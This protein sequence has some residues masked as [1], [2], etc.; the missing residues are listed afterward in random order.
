MTFPRRVLP[1]ALSLLLGLAACG[2]E[3]YDPSPAR[4][5][6]IAAPGEDLAFRDP[7]DANTRALRLSVSP[8]YD[9]AAG[10]VRMF[11]RVEDQ[12]GNLI[13]GLNE[14]NFGITVSPKGAN[15]PVDPDQTTVGTEISAEKITSLTIDSSGSM[16]AIILGTENAT[17]MQV[18]KDAAK[19]F[20]DL[21]ESGDRAAVVDF[22]SDARVAQQLTGDKDALERAID[23]LQAEGAT[24]IGDALSKAIE[25]VGNRPGKRAVILLTDGD[26][27]VDT[28][29]GGPSAWLG[30]PDSTR[31]NALEEAKRANLVVY[32]IGLGEDLSEDGLATLQTIAVE[33][34]GEFFTAIT[35]EDLREVFREEI[36][37][38]VERQPP[39]ETYVLE[40]P[41]PFPADPLADRE[42]GL[43]V[44]VRY[45]NA[46]GNLTGK[47]SASYLVPAR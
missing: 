40:F 30:N 43:L 21:L 15:S 23:A 4:P 29:L 41:S 27:T 12:A 36:P 28:V 6:P 20:V 37:D 18:A 34:G 46:N 31:N 13:V 35:A 22:D 38:A 39:Q 47:Q 32:T 19:L 5:G 26:D 33:T 11:V 1:L 9:E 45:E 3:E 24:N 10:L 8:E 7:T 14:H 2:V 44:T 16:Q 25:A 42:Y 17:R